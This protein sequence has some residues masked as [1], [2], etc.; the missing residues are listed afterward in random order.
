MKDNIEEYFKI[1]STRFGRKLPVTLVRIIFETQPKN[2][3]KTLEEIV[4]YYATTDNPMILDLIEN[5]RNLE[6]YQP[7]E[8]S[9]EELAKMGTRRMTKRES[10]K[11]SDEWYKRW[12]K[13]LEATK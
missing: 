12:K 3:D 6:K 7:R 4:E 11:M 8:L 1:L 9:D 5:A 2:S 13:K 10:K